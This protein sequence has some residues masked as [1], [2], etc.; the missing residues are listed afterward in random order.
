VFSA[1]ARSGKFEVK[2]SAD[3]ARELGSRV[4]ARLAPGVQSALRLTT[5]RQDELRPD[6]RGLKARG[7]ESAFEAKTQAATER[8]EST[9][10]PDDLKARSEALE[11]QV[12]ILTHEMTSNAQALESAR[13]EAER[14]RQSVLNME[15]SY[16]CRL[17]T[18]TCSYD[19]AGERNKLAAAQKTVQT[20]QAQLERQKQDLAL[21]TASRDDVRIRLARL[22]KEAGPATPER[23]TA[24]GFYRTEAKDGCKTRLVL[25]VAPGAPLKE[26]PILNEDAEGDELNLGDSTLFA[27]VDRR[28]RVVGVEA[29]DRQGQTQAYSEIERDRRGRLNR[30]R[31]FDANKSLLEQHQWNRKGDGYAVTFRGLK[32]GDVRA[33]VEQR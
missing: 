25:K 21:T 16:L 8:R 17:S 9:P 6:L 12:P 5:S 31:I 28:R 3:E 18:Y 22:T 11:R 27:C 14:L 1:A 33:V 26:S 23:E 29:V 32:G 2:G 30:V 19:I 4:V 10:G 15:S 7:P 13:G 20:R 24:T